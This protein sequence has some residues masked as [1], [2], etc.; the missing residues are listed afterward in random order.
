MLRRNAR[1]IVAYYRDRLARDLIERRDSIMRAM[2][3]RIPHF[4]IAGYGNALCD[5]FST[6]RRDI[7]GFVKERGW[8][9]SAAARQIAALAS[10]GR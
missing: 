6:R 2:A 7:L 3:G 9:A 5:T 10:R 1:L 8:D 4:E